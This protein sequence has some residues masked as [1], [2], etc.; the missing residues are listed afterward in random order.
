LHEKYG[1]IK[2]QLLT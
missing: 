1:D 2:K